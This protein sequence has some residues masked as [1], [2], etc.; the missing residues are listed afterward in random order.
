MNCLNARLAKK[1]LQNQ[2]WPYLR[3]HNRTSQC[4]SEE[5]CPALPD[6][7]SSPRIH[8]KE[9]EMSVHEWKEVSTSRASGFWI[10]ESD[11]IVHEF[12]E[13]HLVSCS[14]TAGQVLTTLL[15]TPFFG[16]ASAH[17]SCSSSARLLLHYH[18][19]P[20]LSSDSLSSSPTVVLRKHWIY[21]IPTALQMDMRQTCLLNKEFIAD[22]HV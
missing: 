4:Q 7:K 9:R 16:R 6:C 3:G 19:Y 20:I 12:P 2:K 18:D 17:C 22:L 14:G 13:L 1:Q 8:R 21:F 11:T 15:P 10:S 5:A